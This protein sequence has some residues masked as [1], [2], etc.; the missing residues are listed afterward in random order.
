MEK[1]GIWEEKWK[2]AAF[3]VDTHQRIRLRAL[4]DILQELANN[5]ANYRQCGFEHMKANG[6]FWVLNRQSIEINEWPI[7]EQSIKVE[8]WISLMKGPFSMR[9]FAVYDTTERVI[10][11]AS[12]LWTSIERAKMKPATIPDGKFPIIDK[13]DFDLP[14]PSKIKIK[15]DVVKAMEYQI[16]DNDLDVIGHTNNAI[17]LEW[18]ANMIADQQIPLKR[19][20]A[21][22][23][24]ESLIGQDMVI[25]LLQDDQSAYSIEV[26][27]HEGENIFRA[28]L[29]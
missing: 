27:N 10:V 26:L 16:R 7:W 17:Y 9:H 23:T 18:V 14:Q 20:N 4:A 11:K 1:N 8:S 13:R 19:I 24:G 25:N 6:K 15:G 5:H 28:Q 29:K 3:M 22:Y 2:V 12:Y 21:N